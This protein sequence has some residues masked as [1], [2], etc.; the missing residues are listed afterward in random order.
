MADISGE[1]VPMVQWFEER[2]FESEAERQAILN[3]ALTEPFGVPRDLARMLFDFA[4]LVACMTDQHPEL[5]VLDFGAGSGWITELLAR[6]GKR[7]VAFDIHTNLEPCLRSRIQADRRIASENIGFQQG[8]GHAMP[9]EDSSFSN[10]LC[11]DTLHH[12]YDYPKVFSEFARVIR[13]GGRAVF[14]EPGAKHSTSSGT[15]AFL[16]EQKKHDPTW[17]ERDVVLEE[18]DA[19]ARSSNFSGL[20]IVPMPHLGSFLKYSLVDWSQFRSLLPSPQKTLLR[21]N[22]CD[23]LATLNYNDR[24]VF[25]ADRLP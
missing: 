17:I 6:T 18:I 21:K 24:V 20:T 19:I 7:V 11:Y 8:D 12:M 14:V 23:Y 13:P 10:L 22:L 2:Q 3:P 4:V 1:D 16:E 15:I 5:P 9:F 25:Y